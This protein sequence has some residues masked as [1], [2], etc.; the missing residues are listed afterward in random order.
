M[1][2]KV[3]IWSD[4][5]CP[6]CYIGKRKFEKALEQFTHKGE[7]EIRWRSFQLAPDL[8]TDTTKDVYDYLAERKGWTRDYTKKVHHQLEVTAKEVGLDYDF[9]RAIPANSLKAHRFSH[10]AARYHVQDVAEERLFSAYFKEGK[11]IDDI[12]TLVELGKE[13]GIPAE[14]VNNVLQSDEYAK[15][16][17]QDIYKAQQVGVR[18]VPFFVFDNKYAVSGAQPSEVFLQTLKR[19]YQEFENESHTTASSDADGASCSTDGDC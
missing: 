9:D 14:E 6:F 10:L 17:Q 13:L 4:V 11:N 15:E 18:G 5:M 8:I 2:M 19:S 1:T 3:E 7:I 16:V 12:A